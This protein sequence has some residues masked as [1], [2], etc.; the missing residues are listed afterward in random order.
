[1]DSMSGSCVIWEEKDDDWLSEGMEPRD[2]EA[3][4]LASFECTLQS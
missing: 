3:E 2:E 1:M 4:E